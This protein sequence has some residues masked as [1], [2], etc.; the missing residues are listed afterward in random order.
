MWSLFAG[1]G[2]GV[3]D[4]GV[5]SDVVFVGFD[6]G[7]LGIGWVSCGVGRGSVAAGVGASMTLGSTEANLGVVDGSEGCT[8]GVSNDPK[9]SKVRDQPQRRM[10]SPKVTHSLN[11]SSTV[12]FPYSTS[13]PLPRLRSYPPSVHSV[14]PQSS[15]SEASSP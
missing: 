8:E 4:V 13:I 3:V 1:E 11:S 12:H 9:N 2:V 6:G 5:V 7:A 10:R 15:V 14:H